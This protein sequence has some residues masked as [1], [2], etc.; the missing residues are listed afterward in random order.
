[1]QPQVTSKNEEQGKVIV[2]NNEFQASTS[3]DHEKGKEI[4]VYNKFELLQDCLEEDVN[5]S[6]K[7]PQQ[8]SPLV[9]L[10]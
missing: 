5:I 2:T 10:T 8:S 6:P 4:I 3:A 9:G 1:M 7:G